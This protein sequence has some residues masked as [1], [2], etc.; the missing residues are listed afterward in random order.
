M[1]VAFGIVITLQLA[2]LGW[3]IYHSSQC[4][5]FHERV[6]KLEADSAAM[7][8]EI[9]DHENGLRGSMHEL[10]NTI[11]PMYLDWQRSKR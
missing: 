11:S 3:F 2:L 6:A 9:G 7:K 5:A 8:A 1:E 10:R 4:S